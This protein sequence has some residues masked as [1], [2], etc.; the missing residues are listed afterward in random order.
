[1]TNDHWH[2]AENSGDGRKIIRD[3]NRLFVAEVIAADAEL[4]AMAPQMARTLDA[5]EGL[6]KECG[7]APD[8]ARLLVL[9]GA[10][11]SA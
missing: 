7:I 10:V 3:E 9:L 6:C 1:M 8:S 2:V 5:I 11:E 4:V